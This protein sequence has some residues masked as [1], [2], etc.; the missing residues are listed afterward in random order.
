MCEPRNFAAWYSSLRYRLFSSSDWRY[1]TLGFSTAPADFFSSECQYL[2]SGRLSDCPLTC[3]VHSGCSF[4]RYVYKVLAC[5]TRRVFKRILFVGRSKIVLEPCSLL[6][7]VSL[8]SFDGAAY[9]PKFVLHAGLGS[10]VDPGTRKPIYTE[11]VQ[12]K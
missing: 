2:T 10:W 8:S 11:G 6:T 5:I 7:K 3:V 1:L 4:C 9:S 12:Y